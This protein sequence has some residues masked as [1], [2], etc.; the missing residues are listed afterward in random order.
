MDFK[1][2]LLTKHNLDSRERKLKENS[3]NQYVNRLKSMREKEIYNE[4][5]E[6]KSYLIEKIKE[7][8]DDWKTYTKTIE[9]YLNYQKYLLGNLEVNRFKTN[10]KGD[11]EYFQK[12]KDNIQ[13]SGEF[14]GLF[15]LCNHC[16]FQ[17]VIIHSKRDEIA[18]PICPQ[19]GN[20]ID[21]TN[22][23]WMNGPMTKLRKK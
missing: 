8:Y 22:C 20:E 16:L 14:R 12:L 11:T 4:E 19:C 23:E 13:Y 7:Q 1:E 17:G 5:K 2:Y 10:K 9:H 6:L 18:E 3:A 21:F 15:F